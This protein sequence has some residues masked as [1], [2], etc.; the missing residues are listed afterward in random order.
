[1]DCKRPFNLPQCH[2]CLTMKENLLFVVLDPWSCLV[3]TNSYLTMLLVFIN[4]VSAC[5]SVKLQQEF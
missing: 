2:Y 4:G 1:M 5:K 3:E